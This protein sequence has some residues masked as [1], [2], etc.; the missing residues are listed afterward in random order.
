M[1]RPPLE[2]VEFYLL[3]FTLALF[4]SGRLMVARAVWT[5]ALV[6]WACRAPGRAR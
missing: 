2:H 4:P 1:D 3:G 5:G 6:A